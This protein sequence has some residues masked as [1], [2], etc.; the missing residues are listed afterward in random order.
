MYSK[1]EEEIFKILNSNTRGLDSKEAK[2]RLNDF[3]QNIIL[4]KKKTPW[5][6]TEPID[7]IQKCI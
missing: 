2:K 4:N 5:I 1:K 7:K 3:G 6:T